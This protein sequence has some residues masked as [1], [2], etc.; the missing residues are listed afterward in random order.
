MIRHAF[1]TFP[2][3]QI[4]EFLLENST[5]Y[6]IDISVNP[7][8]GTVFHLACK[9]GKFDMADMILKNSN[10]FGIDFNSRF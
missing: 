1:D 7:F 4:A 2:P 10:S 3:L 6:D 9:S 5:L 8:Y